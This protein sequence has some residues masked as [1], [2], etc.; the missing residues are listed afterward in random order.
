MDHQGFFVGQC[1]STGDTE[2]WIPTP[3]ELGS[4]PAVNRFD[5]ANPPPSLHLYQSDREIY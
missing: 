2:R 4:N 5:E 3:Q 1:C